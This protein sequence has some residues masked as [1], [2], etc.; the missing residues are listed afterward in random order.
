MGRTACCLP[1]LPGR[2]LGRDRVDLAVAPVKQSRRIAPASAQSKPPSGNIIRSGGVHE[3]LTVSSTLFSAPFCTIGTSRGE[4]VSVK[5]L[6]SLEC[7]LDSRGRWRQ[8]IAPELES[9]SAWSAI[10]AAWGPDGWPKFGASTWLAAP[11]S[12]HDWL[13]K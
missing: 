4:A 11:C 13:T 6:R 8:P 12:A 9:I 1:K 5:G 10:F 3:G 7:S 2:L